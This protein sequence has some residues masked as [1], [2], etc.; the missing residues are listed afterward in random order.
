M[1]KVCLLIDSLKVGGKERVLSQ[2]AGYFSTRP[3]IEVH[4]ILF[5]NYEVVHYPVPEAVILHVPS[6]AY[7]RKRRIW[8]AFKSLV[9]VRRQ[10]RRIDPSVLMSFGEIWNSF[11]LLAL[12]GLPYRLYISDRCQP[13]RNYNRVQRFLRKWLYPR[14]HGI[15]AQTAR[16][17]EIFEKEFGHRN[18]RVIGNPIREIK[19]HVSRNGEDLTVLTVGRLIPG[20]N[21][22]KLIEVFHQIGMEDWKLLIVGGDLANQP[23]STKLQAYIRDLGAEKSVI[24]AGEQEDVDPFYLNSDIFAFMSDSEGFPNVIG[25]AQSAGLPVVAYDCVAGPS[26]MI[27]DG[28]NGYL[29]PLHDAGLFRERL[30]RLMQDAR[31]RKEFGERAKASIRRFSLDR[32]GASYISF[33]LEEEQ[34]QH[35][36]IAD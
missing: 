9:F 16:A 31:L 12:Y 20:K 4:L 10:V 11:V 21:H 29:V 5:G 26:D 22:Q 2:L 19:Q 6:F 27:I 8:Y 28:E 23:L 35:E 14:A 15:I 32:I 13:D 17:K 24:L 30:Q 34:M 33:L 25:E 18:V 3:G 1:K 36:G 7:Q